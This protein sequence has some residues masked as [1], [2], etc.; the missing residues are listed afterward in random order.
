MKNTPGKINDRLD[1]KGEK[2]SELEDLATEII[3]NESYTH[4]LKA[5]T[6]TST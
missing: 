1:K 6:T 4:R 3:H 2:I 5:T